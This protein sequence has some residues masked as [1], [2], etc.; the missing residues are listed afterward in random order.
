MHDFSLTHIRH[1]SALDFSYATFSGSCRLER[2]KS[3]AQVRPWLHSATVQG[4]LLI[5]SFGGPPSP[6]TPAL[7]VLE[8]I[9]VV[10]GGNLTVIMGDDVDA[11]YRLHLLKV[12]GEALVV[13]PPQHKTT[14]AH[15]RCLLALITPADVRVPHGPT[16]A[17]DTSLS[18]IQRD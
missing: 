5:N 18:S 10:E 16:V 17:R 6:T 3:D 2:I 4:N 11:Q 13:L 12:E 1:S 7:V 9:R 14:I 8:Q 15:L